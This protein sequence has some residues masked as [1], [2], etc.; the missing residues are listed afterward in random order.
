M[1]TL[2]ITQSN[3]YCH[4]KSKLTF[5]ESVALK[6]ISTS[7]LTKYC[8]TSPPLI[9]MI[10]STR[11]C[12]KIDVQFLSPT[13]NNSEILMPL[14]FLRYEG[15][16][17]WNFYQRDVAKE[18]YNATKEI[19]TVENI[20][21]FNTD[22]LNYIIDGDPTEIIEFD[23]RVM[24]YISLKRGKELKIHNRK[25]VVRNLITNYI[26]S[27]LEI[28][29]ETRLVIWLYA[30]CRA[31][32]IILPNTIDDTLKLIEDK[33]YD[34]NLRVTEDITAYMYKKLIKHFR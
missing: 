21:M 22:D 18:T 9:C 30:N 8:R 7:E 20:M 1:S 3:M 17:I 15:P 19:Y 11:D 33:G 4:D 31:L 6:S 28:L 12:K 10:L 27:K 13:P 26:N 34:Y 23:L 16:N 32:G 5:F 2:D 24:Y 29:S 14:Y 25:K